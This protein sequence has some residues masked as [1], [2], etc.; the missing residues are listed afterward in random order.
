[1]IVFQAPAKHH[2]SQ[3]KI[4]FLTGLSYPNSCELSTV[5]KVFLSRINCCETW[6]V[7]Q[8]FPYIDQEKPLVQASKFA[9]EIL[10]TSVA[11]IKQ[12]FAAS[13]LN[14][15]TAARKHLIQLAASTEHLFLIVGSCGLEILNHA[16]TSEVSKKLRYVF[17][18][19]AVARSLPSY[20]YTLI[21][22]SQDYIS[23]AFFRKAHRVVPS[24]GHLGYL[25]N[26]VVFEHIN[27]ALEQE[28]SH[29]K[30]AL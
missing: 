14:Y 13:S 12:Y 22:G 7:Y 17:A 23:K 9:P 4:A 20:N 24:L 18:F 15:K 30:D 16:L 28:L 2:Y 27:S 3:V 19:G 25:E 8:N 10:T 1:V 5:Q 11:N 26:A 6:K 21:Q 29:L